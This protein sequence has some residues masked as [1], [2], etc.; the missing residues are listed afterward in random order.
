MTL[1]GQPPEQPLN[2]RQSFL[3]GMAWISL[4][5]GVMGLLA[6]IAFHFPE[7]LTTPALREVYQ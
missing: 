4:F 5:L 3:D 6:V 1:C 2:V 7:Y